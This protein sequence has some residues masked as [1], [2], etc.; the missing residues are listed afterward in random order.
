MCRMSALVVALLACSPATPAPKL[1][2]KQELVGE[3]IIIWPRL[4][5]LRVENGL[6]NEPKYDNENQNVVGY[7]IVKNFD[8]YVLVFKEQGD[9]D[10]ANALVCSGTKVKVTARWLGRSGDRRFIAA[11]VI[12]PLKE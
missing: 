12:T 4:V 11:D 2:E 1:P 7:V 5:T 10:K 3:I 9:E 8:F 6:K